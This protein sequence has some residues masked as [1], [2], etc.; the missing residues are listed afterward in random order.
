MPG[1]EQIVST[2]RSMAAA[3]RPSRAVKIET[4]LDRKEYRP[5]ERA[6]ISFRLTD[7]QH[8]PMPGALSLAAVDEAVLRKACGER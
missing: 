6:K 5:G 2:S 7:D 8:R 4:T 3:N 1:V